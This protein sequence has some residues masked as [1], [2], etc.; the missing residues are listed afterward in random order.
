MMFQFTLPQNLSLNC[1]FMKI[2]FTSFTALLIT[3]MFFF[4]RVAV[5]QEVLYSNHFD[6]PAGQ[7]PPGWT[8]DGAQAP[9]SVSATAM[10]GGEAPELFLGYSFASGLSRLISPEIN[11][12]GYHELCLRFKQYLFNYE[13]D[14]G[15]I[16]GLDVTY[17]GGATWEVLMEKPVG[18][19]NI[20]QDEFSWYF[21]APENAEKLQIAF[22]FDGN[23]YAINFWAIDDLFVESPVE[24]DLLTGNFSGN[25]TPEAGEQQLYFLEVINGGKL[26][27]QDYTVK[28]YSADGAQLSSEAGQPIAFGE[29]MYHLLWWTPSTDNIGSMDIY[30]KI[31]FAQDEDQDNNRTVDLPVY[32]QPA[33]IQST[34]IGNGSCPLNSLPCNFFNLHSF[35]Q[36]LY[37][38]E[39]VGVSGYPITGLQ[40]T[41]QFDNDLEDVPVQILMGETSLSSLADNWADPATL[42]P[43]FN[44]TINFAKG[45]NTIYIPLDNPYTYHGGNLVVQT[46]KSYSEMVLGAVF[47]S[48]IDTGASRSRISERDDLPFDPM[49]LPE[50]GYSSDYYPNITLFYS[51]GTTMVSPLQATP[52]VSAY[53]NPV[54]SRLFVQSVEPMTEVRITD[55]SG[56]DIF[57]EKA[58]SLEHTVNVENLIPGMYMLQI[59][60]D[61]GTATRKIQVIR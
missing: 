16:I 29:K 10:A 51:T 26:A 30:A 57:R 54:S 37:M 19:L 6:N 32:V 42:T 38:P 33:G 12:D 28:L 20:P 7:L 21:T 55:L 11:I 61:A 36:S 35:T 60:T 47:I 44:G 8:L 53:P 1:T 58:A 17:D 5:G 9:W 56:R 3:G 18:M 34:Q 2:V 45:F 43:V 23:N 13:M 27:Q 40:Y 25:T 22:R 4:N 24:N 14:Y 52:V 48:S 46:V 59:I 39:E 15:E 41:C 31:E 50:F 49:S